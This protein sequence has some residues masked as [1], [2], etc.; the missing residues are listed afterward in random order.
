MRTSSSAS[1]LRPVLGEVGSDTRPVHG[2]PEA[3]KASQ[4]AMSAHLA[5]DRDRIAEGMNEIV[6]RRMF[7]AGL[8]LESALGLLGDHCAAGMVRE[9]VSELDLAV[10]DLR[11]LVFEHLRPE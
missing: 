11:D 1:F 2:L 6:V 3:M 4:A 8:A 5:Q 7:A 10:R 9:A